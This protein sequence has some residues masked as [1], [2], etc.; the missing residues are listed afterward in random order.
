MMQARRAG[1]RLYVQS[2][3][4][5]EQNMSQDLHHKEIPFLV[6]LYDV[7]CEDAGPNSKTI[8]A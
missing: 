4:R 2:S 6:S 5:D 1:N 7:G 8:M 3:L